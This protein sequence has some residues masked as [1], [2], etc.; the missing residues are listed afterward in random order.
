LETLNRQF[1]H[2]VENDYNAVPHDAIGM[3]P[4]DRFGVDLARLRFLPPSEHNDEHSKSIVSRAGFAWCSASPA[5]AR[6]SS[7]S[8]CNASP[9]TNTSSP[10]L[11]APCTL[12]PTPSKSFATPS[13]SSSNVRRLNVNAASSNRPSASTTP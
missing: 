9:K 11:G 2:W 5:L 8:P 6:P 7:S 4:I 3:K 1:T 13:A 12:T 10:P